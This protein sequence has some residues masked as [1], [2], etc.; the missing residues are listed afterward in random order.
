MK[1]QCERG[2]WWEKWKEARDT[3][4]LPE[5]DQGDEGELDDDN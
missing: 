1:I 2:S 4:S 3:P 5:E